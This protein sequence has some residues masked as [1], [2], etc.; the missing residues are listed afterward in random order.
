MLR[1]AQKL[2][3]AL[4]L[5]P[6]DVRARDR[7]SEVL[8]L[9]FG[10]LWSRVPFVELEVTDAG[11][12]WGGRPVLEPPD[13]REGLLST[14]RRGGVTSFTLV[15][16]VERVEIHQLLLAV[17]EARAERRPESDLPTLL[18]RADLRLLGY[19]LE[20]G[21]EERDGA[22]PT[23]TSS[24][25]AS[26]A[27]A[28][29][30]PPTVR[31]AVRE[32]VAQSERPRGI[33]QLESYDSTLYFLEPREIEYLRSA[34]DREYAQDHAMNALAL[35]L[36]T[37]ELRHEPEVRNEVL[38]ILSDLLPHLLG[39]GRFDAVAYLMAETREVAQR[40][41]L[42]PPQ[43]DGLDALRASV[44]EPRA[45]AQLFHALDDGG[46]RP[47]QES[48]GILLRELRPQAIRQILGWSELLSSAEAKQAVTS[49][50]EAFFREWPH[51]LSRMLTAE[52]PE[53]V[54]AALELA[55]RVKLP[56]FAEPV[57]EIAGH[58]DRS[59]RAGVGRALA[60]IGTGLALRCL[61]AMADDEDASVR[62]EVWQTFA[63][64]PLRGALGTLECVVTGKQLEELEQREKRA[65]F[66]AYGAV[67]GADGVKTLTSM[68]RGK[69]PT[70]GRLSAHSRACAAVGLG[71]V[72]TPAA[73]KALESA[74]AD[75]DPVV[76]AAAGS[77]LRGERDA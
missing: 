1:S 75:R 31:D 22:H 59:I 41:D 11:V 23:S 57:S 28:A 74:M 69:S 20:G 24:G 10:P 56:G 34:I 16:G 71:V 35:L 52:E 8:R 38:G 17:R 37:L 15:P 65:L 40:A 29:P 42:E 62:L 77:A 60:A 54:R 44:S 32:D 70:G 9:S 4:D 6:P 53:S 13:D 25:R 64:R 33:V 26:E 76:R 12:L 30:P 39:E 73:R 48:M 2:L 5:E 19:G 3:A 49:S 55:T 43:K 61:L 14:L 18:F 72:G 47:T 46:V 21:P 66:T 51:A 63:A 50:L 58:P 67:A 68:L 45:V 36:D 7:A 27:G